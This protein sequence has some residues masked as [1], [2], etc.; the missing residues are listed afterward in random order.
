MAV[1]AIS[2]LHLSFSTNKPMTIFGGHWEDYEQRIKESW[3]AQVKPEDIV[4]IGG[5]ISWAMH[6]PEVKPDLD[7]ISELPGR[8]FMIKGNHDFWW[9][10]LTKLKSGWPEIEFMHNN[11]FLVDNIAIAGSRGWVCP[12][13]RE[14]SKD[15][16]KI[17]NRELV[18]FENSLKQAKK[19]GGEALIAMLH[20]PPTNEKFEDSGFTALCETY[21]VSHL[22]Y[23]HLHSVEGFKV[24]IKGERGGVHYHLTSCDYL[25]FEV[26]QILE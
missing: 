9:T 10:S 25:S 14:F 7:F 8:K 12:N 15:D 3:L 4:L 11:A 20:Y 19:L 24:G 6:L 26:K 1:F 16:L 18:R 13:S 22:I 23:G 5:D 2:D 21:G 17:Y